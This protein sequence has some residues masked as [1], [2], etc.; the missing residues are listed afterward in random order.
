MTAPP[1]SLAEDDYCYLTTMGRVSGEPHTVE[2]WFGLANG[3]LYMLSGS[4]KDAISDKPR[5]DWV[6]N[7]LRHPAVQLRVG[8][9]TYSGA[10]RLVTDTAEDAL[11]RRL[12]VEKYTPRHN[13]ELDSWGRS[14][15]PVAIDF[16]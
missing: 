11:A 13:G 2:I 7:I 5:A 3:V 9:M 6:R 4:G 8:E 12:L 16:D 1:A 15:L 14:A 10:G